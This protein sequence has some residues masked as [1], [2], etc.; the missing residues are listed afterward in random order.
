MVK[1]NR[2]LIFFVLILFFVGVACN[3]PFLSNKD[4]E[5]NQIEENGEEA[6]SETGNNPFNI[7]PEASPTEVNSQPVGIQAGLGSFD[8]YSGRL[9]VMISSSD[10]TKNEITETVERDVANSAAHSITESVSREED[11]TEDDTSSQEVIT[12]GVVTCTKDEDTWEYSDQSDQSKELA[13][14]FKQMI[15]F[16]P[17]I[18]NP[19]Y[20]GEEE[21]SGVETNHFTFQISGIGQNS[22]SVATINEG[23][24]WLAIDGQYLVKY[25][26]ELEVRSAAEGSADAEVTTLKV[27]YDLTNINQPLNI[28]LPEDCKPENK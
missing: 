8:S 9:Y 28:T 24:Y 5:S 17:I 12:S 18:D 26:L 14:I 3:L 23:E 2:S 1:R 10:G 16:S 15:D 19:V 13:D 11:E 21:M 25:E 22:G 4:S 27:E 20:I 7:L 6:T